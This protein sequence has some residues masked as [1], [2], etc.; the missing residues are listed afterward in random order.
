MSLLLLNFAVTDMTDKTS[1]HTPLGAVILITAM[2]ALLQLPLLFFGIDMADLGF[3]MTHYA[4]VFDNPASVE[5]N[6][7]YY[8]TGI[9]GGAWLKL[10]GWVGLPGIF[11]MRLLGMLCNL[12]CVWM[13][14]MLSILIMRDWRP[15]AM[16]V[17]L[18]VCGL[19][20]IPITFCYDLLTALLTVGSLY[21]LL[22]SVEDGATRGFAIGSGILMGMALFARVANAAGVLYLLLYPI[23]YAYSRRDM[24]RQVIAWCLGWCA[25]VIAIVLLMLLK[26]DEGIFLANMQDLFSIA[27]GHEGETSHGLRSMILAQFSV[28]GRI[29]DVAV[30]GAL[31]VGFY[32]WIRRLNRSKWIFAICMLPVA[33]LGIMLVMRTNITL[34]LAG[35]SLLGCVCVLALSGKGERRLRMFAAAGLLMMAVM[36]LGSDGGI[37]NN[38][39]AALWMGLPPAMAYFA[40]IGNL[41][42]IKEWK[43]TAGMIPSAMFTAIVFLVCCRRMLLGGVYFDA[44]PIR[45]MTDQ[46]DAPQAAWIR[47]SPERAVIINDIVAEVKKNVSPGDTLMVYGCGATV[48]YLTDTAPF[49]GCSW[50]EQLSASALRQRLQ[51]A[52]GKPA[53]LVLNFSTYGDS[54]GQPSQAYAE[55]ADANIYHTPEKSGVVTAWLRAHD[56]RPI[57]RSEYFTLYKPET[58]KEK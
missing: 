17:A 1:K 32:V 6:Y 41:R 46:I 26:G 50:P 35:V 40:N 36:P 13:V 3:Y 29:I 28:W 2:A 14:S 53:V 45:E 30:K 27:S 10:C 56:Y 7:M 25:G 49:I 43:L 23:A 12:G 38:G 34:L 58:T 42:K 15:V 24:W 20:I 37:M 39:V 47:T 54:F 11:G 18:T 21:L 44:T 57:T 5:Y 51:E 55:G 19:F 4:Q 16:A 48:N 8:L 52:S 33:I 22:R 31:L 9:V